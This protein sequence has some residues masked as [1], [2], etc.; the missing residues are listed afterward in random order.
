MR[1]LRLL[2]LQ[3]PPLQ[4]WEPPLLGLERLLLAGLLLLLVAGLLLLP[5]VAGRLLGLLL[6]GHGTETFH[7]D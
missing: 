5:L 3:E 6:P 1:Q 2:L 7:V 4:E